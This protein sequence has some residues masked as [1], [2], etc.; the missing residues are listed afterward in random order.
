MKSKYFKKLKF[1]NNSSVVK[2]AQSLLTLLFLVAVAGTVTWSA[3]SDEES[4]DE[5]TITAG[6]LDLQIGGND[7]DG[8]AK[9]TVP[10]SYPGMAEAIVIDSYINNAGSVAMNSGV[11]FAVTSVQDNEKWFVG[12]RSRRF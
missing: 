1:K 4:S 6:T 12:T 2:I 10:N 7:L 11:T 5:N 3:W 8:S 9:V